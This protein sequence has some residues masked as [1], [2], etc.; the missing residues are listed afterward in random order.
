[1]KNCKRHRYHLSNKRRK[2]NFRAKASCN[3]RKLLEEENDLDIEI[4]RVF[5]AKI[6]ESEALHDR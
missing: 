1:M 4:A 6:F 2:E 5:A 3:N